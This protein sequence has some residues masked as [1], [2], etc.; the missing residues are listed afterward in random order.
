MIIYRIRNNV[1][2]LALGSCSTFSPTGLT[3]V[4]AAVVAGGGVGSG[5]K[6]ALNTWFGI[7]IVR[8][9]QHGG[10]AC[11]TTLEQYASEAC[12]LSSLL[13]HLN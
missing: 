8:F 6:V 7:I 2:G 13:G 11:T 12:R 3:D 5:T 1:G 4:L 9:V 10:V